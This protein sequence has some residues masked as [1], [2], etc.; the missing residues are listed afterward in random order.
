MDNAVKTMLKKKKI[1]TVDDLSGWLELSVPTVRRRLRSWKA[2]TSYNRNGLYY[3]LPEIPLFNSNGLWKFREV[4]FS[5][6][7]TLK[8]TVVSLVLASAAGLSSGELGKIIGLDPRSFLSHYR[9]HPQLCRERN[10]REFIWFSSDPE[11]RAKQSE[12]R[13]LHSVKTLSDS[14]VVV[15]LVEFIRHSDLDFPT[16]CEAVAHH[17]PQ[18]SSGMLEAFL[19]KHGLLKKTLDSRRQDCSDR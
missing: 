5:M 14:E 3:T 12:V 9:N 10:G 15:V 11:I 13:Y 6:H 17:V 4:R 7:G 1:F 18:V 16:L 8:E 19:I 2:I